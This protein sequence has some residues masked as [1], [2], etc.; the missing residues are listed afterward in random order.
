MSANGGPANKRV[1]T[2]VDRSQLVDEVGE[3]AKSKIGFAIV[4][5]GRAGQFHLA[6]IKMISDIATLEW[7]IDSDQDK[8]EKLANQ[9]GCRGGT[10]IQGALDDPKVHAVVIASIT[11]SHYGYCKRAL[12][13]GKAVFTEKPISH[14]PEELEEIIDMAC[15][16]KNAFVVGYQR[17][18]D[19]NFR[20]LRHEICSGSIGK[21]RLIKCCSRDNP[22]PPLEY[23]RVSGGIFF[24]MLCHDFDMIHF[25]SG[26]ELPEEVYSIGHCYDECVKEMDDI[27]MVVVT[28]RFPSGL[29][30]SVDC[31]RIA[32]YGYDQRV[33]AF[34][35]LGMASANNEVS[36]TVV[37][38]TNK[39]F[40][41]P[42]SEWSFAERYKHTYT[43]EL[44]EFAAL[45][46]AKGVES[47]ALVRRHLDLD[48]VTAAAEL[49]YRLQR[50]VKL[51]EVQELRCKLPH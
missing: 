16:S 5:L 21:L 50:P 48:K 37:V 44:A 3:E 45:V 13:A 42:M 7:A 9:E 27:D 28:L 49:S 15:Q 8:V 43:L 29:M 31:S 30:A 10:D 35:E 20:A 51:A 41:H 12:Q 22:M 39:G 4:G 36:S 24:D 26:G 1:R 23:L 25:L 34:G 38:A 33:E 11:Y 17:R 47:E 40:K 6:S 18:S 19:K 14:N 2:V 32:A 46:K